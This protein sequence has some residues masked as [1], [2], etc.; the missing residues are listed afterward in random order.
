M[1]RMT[2]LNPCVDHPIL[3]LDPLLPTEP[4]PLSLTTLVGL[5]ELLGP[6]VH[7]WREPR[8]LYGGQPAGP[9]SLPPGVPHLLAGA[10]N[11]SLLG[12]DLPDAVVRQRLA[13]GYYRVAVYGRLARS[14]RFLAEATSR[15]TPDRVW[16]ML[17]GQ[18][19]NEERVT[20]FV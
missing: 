12:P 10:L 4:D 16:A 18:P 17:T 8:Y 9:T 15:L 19:I 20:Q 1:L 11:A 14:A 13:A 6:N 2:S 3:F 5:R 7:V